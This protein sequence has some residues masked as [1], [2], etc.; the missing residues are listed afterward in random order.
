MKFLK[1]IG[2]IFAILL[3]LLFVLLHA[4]ERSS[5]R[6]YKTFLEEGQSADLFHVVP[7]SATHPPYIIG[8]NPTSTKAIVGVHGSPGNAE[9][10]AGFFEDEGVSS[11]KQ[12]VAYD[13][14]GYGLAVDKDVE[15]ELRQEAEY[16]HRVI[17]HIKADTIILLGHSYGCSVV[18]QYLSEYSDHVYRAVLIGSPIDPVLEVGHWWRNIVD[19]PVIRWLVPKSLR[20]CN[21]EIVALKHQLEILEPQLAKIKSPIVFYQGEKDYLVPRENIYYFKDRANP[22]IGHQYIE[23]EDDGHFII[24]TRHDDVVD[25]IDGLF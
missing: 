6:A 25:I 1:I 12:V 8:G 5:N 3:L 7:E 23:V 22:E 13:R 24:W 2:K 18:L 20:R 4:F 11:S 15:R 19:S 9:F 14:P 16:L 21:T 17:E 10:M